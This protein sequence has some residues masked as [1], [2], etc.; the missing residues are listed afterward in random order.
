LTI[1][2]APVLNDVSPTSESS[3]TINWSASVGATRYFLDVASVATFASCLSGYSNCDAGAGTSFAV[4][5][6]STGTIY[7]FRLRAYNASGTSQNS[8]VKAS[9]TVPDAPVAL[10]ATAVTS[11]SF[12]AHWHFV[13]G[14]D[15]YSIDV[16]TDPNLTNL[17]SG[18]AN[19]DVG[20]VA[21]IEVDANIA[22]G[23]TY[24]YCVRGYSY[25]GVSG[26]SN[27]VSVLTTPAAPSFSSLKP[28]SDSSIALIWNPSPGAAKYY[29]DAAADAAFTQFV[30]GLSS[31]DVGNATSYLVSGLSAGTTYYFRVRAANTSGMG[32]YSDVQSN[33]TILRAPSAL[34]ASAVTTTSFNANWTVA[35]GASGYFVDVAS[36]MAFT[37]FVPNWQNKDVG[38][39]TGATVSGG[40]AGGTTYYYRVRAYCPTGT[41]E[42]SNAVTILTAPPAPIVSDSISIAETSFSI[43]WGI[44][45][46]AAKYI[47]DVATDSAFTVY[48]DGFRGKDVGAATSLVVSGLKGG[49][50]YFWRVSASNAGGTSAWSGIMKVTTLPPYRIVSGRMSYAGSGRSTIRGA[51]ISLTPLPSG[52]PVFTKSDSL[53]C[54]KFVNIL[55]GN[56]AL[57]A[58][59]TGGHPTNY[60]NAADALMAA[61]YSIDPVCSPL[62][63][64]QR[65]ASD[66]NNDGIVN[67]ADALQIVLRYTGI[68]CSFQ[69]GDWLFVTDSS[70]FA[71][72]AT[73]CVNN[74]EFIAVG[75]VNCDA[76]PAGSCFAKQGAPALSAV[77]HP[78]TSMKVRSTEEF[79]IPIRLTSAATLGSM[80]MRIQYPTDAV[81]FMGVRGPDGIVSGGD[82]SVAVVAWFSADNPLKLKENDVLLS[83]RFKPVKDAA[84]FTLTLDPSSQLTNDKASI[85]HGID[86]TVPPVE[87]LLPTEFALEQNYPNP[88]NPS[89]T[90][91]YSVP[92]ES[93]VTLTIYDI[94]GRTIQTLVQ[95]QCVEGSYPARWEATNMPSGV[96]FCR[97]EAVGVTTKRSFT[98]TKK[99]VLVK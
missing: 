28:A 9:S 35:T 51:D 41:S 74:M 3:V 65:L 77:L 83:L 58:C 72:G 81:T 62:T 18:W 32:P 98:A 23:T 92:T 59:K 21:S 94:C 69:K 49:T 45:T 7:Y 36:D 39:A 88:F 34:A 75:D 97:M 47:L 12:T 48:A 64:V 20:D 1:P 93:K 66:V 26:S 29:L 24:Y 43:Q 14:A 30:S 57:S 10:A 16:A 31:K 6:L 22:G 27:T 99:L 54:F 68:I 84:N 37:S 11:T 46:G 87:V 90:I 73:N 79:E 67:S 55:P 61:L 80:S 96:Y 13:S 5:G 8:N 4:S 42:N 60:V 19:K 63:L 25:G 86:L 70:S 15:G 38:N 50:P 40:I 95:R 76:L 53:G 82:S 33:A 89:T 44:A 85:L 78:G 56:Y 17:V 71:V 52:Q 91:W 2:L